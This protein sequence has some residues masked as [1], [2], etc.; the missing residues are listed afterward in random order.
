M[1][2]ISTSVTTD[3]LA[4]S[5]VFGLTFQGEGKNLGMPCYFLRLAGC[6]LSCVWC[7]TP[8][9]WDWTGKNGKVYDPKQEIHQFKSRDVHEI[10]HRRARADNVYNLVISGGEPLLQQKT[11]IPLVNILKNDGWWIEVETAGTR[12]PDFWLN[13]DQFNVSLK[14][15]NSGNSFAKRHKPEAIKAFVKDPRAYFK[16]VICNEDD[17]RE[18]NEIAIWYSIEPRRIY[19]MPEGKDPDSIQQHTQMMAQAAIRHGWNLTTR[20]QVQLYGNQRGI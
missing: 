4:V 17:M 12:E 15:E 11:L 1:G 20:L 9:T 5:E 14:L 10:L 3:T 16:F 6:N 2:D 19:V 18:V 8:Y 7:D 13:V